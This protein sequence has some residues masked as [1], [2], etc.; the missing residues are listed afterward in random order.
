MAAFSHTRLLKPGNLRFLSSSLQCWGTTV[1]SPDAR[2]LTKSPCVA[3]LFQAVNPPVI[4]GI[5]KPKKPGG[6]FLLSQGMACLE[7]LPDYCMQDT[8]IPVLT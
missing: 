7:L 5:R 2:A 4:N 1:A 8:K 3:V 6:I